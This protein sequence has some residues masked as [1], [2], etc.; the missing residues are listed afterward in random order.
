MCIMRGSISFQKAT[1]STGPDDMYI[2]D[3]IRA[4]FESV[5]LGIVR[6]SFKYADGTRCNPPAGLAVQ[7]G[8][9]VVQQIIDIDFDT[10]CYDVSIKESYT[11]K[12]GDEDLYNIVPQMQSYVKPLPAGS[13]TKARALAAAAAAAAAHVA[14]LG[15]PLELLSPN[16]IS[17][18]A[19]HKRKR[20]VIYE[21]CKDYVVKL[22]CMK[23]NQVVGFFNGFMYHDDQPLILTSGHIDCYAEATNYFAWFFEGTALQQRVELQSLMFGRPVGVN[24]TTDGITYNGHDPDLA[25]FASN[26]PVHDGHVMDMIYRPRPFGAGQPSVGATVFIVGF[27]GKQEPQL[28]IS[29]GH[30]SYA[31]ISC[32]HVSI[33][34][35]ADNGYSGSPV[36]N[37]DGYVVGMVMSGDDKNVVAVPT[38]T[39][40]TWL[41]M[42]ENSYPGFRG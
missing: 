33:T 15:S 9:Q 41:R 17:T 29:E 36:F 25:L 16:V 27:K 13:R 21:G 12:L 39:I 14:A 37:A 2:T 5:G 10:R 30:V 32:F 3:D 40:D 34:A 38:T 35:Y 28:S 6:M 20:K 42:G 18:A 1:G 31:G 11:I 23:D 24:R 8:G 19:E 7:R 26:K 4:V 22:E